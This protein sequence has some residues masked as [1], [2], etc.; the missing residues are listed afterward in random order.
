MKTV[1]PQTVFGFYLSHNP[2][3]F[4]GFFQSKKLK[5]SSFASWIFK[6]IKVSFQW[7]A[8]PYFQVMQTFICKMR[9]TWCVLKSR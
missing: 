3:G 9:E 7:N 6:G 1:I 5:T 8:Y 4:I 2:F